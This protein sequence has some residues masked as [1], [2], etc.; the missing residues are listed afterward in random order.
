MINVS[1]NF[2]KAMQ[3]PVKELKAYIKT[4]NNIY[5]KSSDDLISFSISGEGNI[6]KTTMRKL[7]AKYIGEHNLLGKSIFVAFGVK[8]GEETYEYID[9]GT[10]IVTEIETSKDTDTTSIVGYDLMINTMKNYNVNIEYP[11]TLIDYANIIC[12]LCGLELINNTFVHNNWVIDTELYKNIDGITYR[13]VLEEIAKATAS[14]CIIKNDKVYFKYIE[15]TGEELTYANMFK[16]KL[17]P[18]YGE[19][20]SVVLSRTPQEDNIYMQDDQSIIDNGLTEFKIENN[21]IIDKDRDNAMLPIFNALH[22]ISYYPFETDTEGLGWYEIG[23]RFD[24]I[25]DTNDSF[26]CVLFNFSVTVDGGIKEKLY[27][28]E[29]TKTQTQYQYASKVEKRLKNTEIIVD[30]QNQKITSIVSTQEEQSQKISQQEQTIDEVT[31]I[32]TEQT[33]IITGLSTELEQTNSSFS[34]TFDQLLTQIS[35]IDGQTQTQFS[36]IIKYIRFEDGNIILGEVGNELVLKI[37]NN[38]ISFMQSG[39]EVAYFSN[40]KMYITDGEF[41]NSL[42]LG[43]FGFIPRANGNL[44]FRKVK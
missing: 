23:D 10:F 24:I 5:I 7:E 1:N 21:Q 6:G 41:L 17:E 4:E 2:K 14:T 40:K 9:Y 44:S 26:S 38:R 3:E 29:P 39:V 19:I 30:K 34:F 8:T 35:T 22:G 43:N 11:I 33:N 13:D 37:Q 36:E 32:V 42:T 20:N 31:D 28:K 18:M 15:N 27:T 16:L 25:N 12:G